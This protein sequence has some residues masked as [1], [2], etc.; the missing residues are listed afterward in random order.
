MKILLFLLLLI[1]LVFSV[2]LVIILNKEVT[3][4]IIKLS[5]L[6]KEVRKGNLDVSSDLRYDNEIGELGKGFNQMVAELKI[7]I[8]Q[9]QE[10]EEQKRLLEFRVLES[11]IKPHFL[12]NTLNSIKWM[13]E[14]QNA[15]SVSHAIVALVQL[16]QFN[17]GSPEVLVKVSREIEA[18]KHYILL[19]QLRYWHSFEAFYSIPEETEDLY[20][21]KL[22]LQPIVENS[23]K[24]GLSDMSNKGELT[25]S[26]RIEDGCLVFEITDNGVGMEK[27]Q[28]EKLLTAGQTQGDNI[29]GGIG[30]K[31]VHQ[32]IQL[33]YGERYGISIKSEKDK[34]TRV[35][36]TFPI[37][38]NPEGGNL[39]ENYGGR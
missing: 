13:A 14:M 30:L 21:P 17:M 12:Y 8:R 6:M 22:S 5:M 16:I 33:R 27:G 7:Y 37:I 9:I 18:L 20:I 35:L 36:L 38:Q 26:S 28:A 23:I 4:P 19:Q 32:R 3:R 29:V 31:N 34:G 2:I 39:C 24:H 10:E 15:E 11:Q 1:V 25:L